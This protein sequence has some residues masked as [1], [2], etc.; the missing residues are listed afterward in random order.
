MG[1]IP[2]SVTYFILFMCIGYMGCPMNCGMKKRNGTHPT[3]RCILSR[4]VSTTLM[5]LLRWYLHILLVK[6][7]HFF[8]DAHYFIYCN[9]IP[10]SI[11]RSVSY[12]S[13]KCNV[14]VALLFLPKSGRR[15][16][17][18]DFGNLFFFADILGVL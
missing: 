16:L 12:L 8:P 17:H 14:N 6:K 15:F 10:P 13:F 9:Q 11:S 5:F 4:F 3:M 1:I 18:P 2:R 7:H